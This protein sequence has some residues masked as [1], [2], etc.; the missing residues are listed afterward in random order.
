M[1]RNFRESEIGRGLMLT[2]EASF[3]IFFATAGIWLAQ[4]AVAGFG[5]GDFP[6]AVLEAAGTILGVALAAIG[7]AKAL[8]TANN[9]PTELPN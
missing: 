1:P 6:K 5:E 7:L 9:A 4:S 2:P 3:V 8:K